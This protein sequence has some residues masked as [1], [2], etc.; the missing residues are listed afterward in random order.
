MINCHF[1]SIIFLDSSSSHFICL[2]LFAFSEHHS[3][4][5]Q[6][7]KHYRTLLLLPLGL[8]IQLKM[9]LGWKGGRSTFHADRGGWFFLL[10]SF[11]A[12]WCACVRPMILLLPRALPPPF[13]LWAA[14]W[15]SEGRLADKRWGGAWVLKDWRQLSAWCLKLGKMIMFLNT[16]AKINCTERKNNSLYRRRR[17]PYIFPR[18]SV[19]VCRNKIVSSDIL[20][21]NNVVGI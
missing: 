3:V 5:S 20:N 16:S 9:S 15:A 11:C 13:F 2:P 12:K 18:K 10:S 1:S 19:D 21:K 17:V 6:F 7:H 8:K 14:F 4:F